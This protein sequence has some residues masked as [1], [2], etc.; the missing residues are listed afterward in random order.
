[1]NPGDDNGR[2]R[3]PDDTDQDI[4]AGTGHQSARQSR[5]ADWTQS[6]LAL[7][8]SGRREVGKTLSIPLN[9]NSVQTSADDHTFQLHTSHLHRLTAFLPATPHNNVREAP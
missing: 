9:V 4:T 1:M 3:S 5:N 6:F 2:D 8:H 7:D